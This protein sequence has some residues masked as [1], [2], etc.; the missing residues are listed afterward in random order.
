MGTRP[1][2]DRAP[3]SPLSTLPQQARRARP[4]V[5]LEAL[6]PL[7][8]WP[9]W[10]LCAIYVLPGFIGRDPW[11]AEGVAFG[12][13]W[14]IA[15]GHASWLHPTLYGSAV[16]GG[17]LAYWIGAAS[18]RLLGASLG[19]VLAARLPFALMLGLSMIQTWY[20]AYQL[21]RR[22]AALP[23][24][25][26]FAPPIPARDYARAM[27]DGALLSLVACLGLLVRGHEI[28]PALLQLT[29]SSSLLLAA[30][31]MS[32]APWRAAAL[33]A[34][35]LAALAGGGAPTLAFG[36]L[37]AG[38][39]LLAHR[40]LAGVRV[41]AA[42]ALLVGAA[43]LVVAWHAVARPLPSAP[44]PTLGHDLGNAAWFLWPA[45]PLA[46]WAL[47]RWRA[48]WTEW[49]V[50]APAALLALTL[51]EGMRVSTRSGALLSA[52]PPAALLAALAL[53]V[54]RRGS[55]AALDWFALMFFSL[56][57]FVVWLLWL[58]TL[59][60]FPRQPAA[61]IARLA[62]GYHALLHPLPTLLALA[63]TL[64]WAAV[65]A[66]RAGRHRHPLWKGMVLSAGGVTLVWVLVGTLWLPAL[67]YASTY[68]PLGRRLGAVLR[69]QA[70]GGVHC[71]GLSLAQQAL[72]GYWSGADLGSG[73]HA[74]YRLQHADRRLPPDMRVLWRG[75][76]PGEADDAFV[77]LGPR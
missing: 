9:L 55:L 15:S 62:P 77:L 14:Q 32:L 28:G 6:A 53:P 48:S 24:Q 30:A 8:R 36:A 71:A 57:A 2:R 58:A 49:H 4:V 21:A 5:A 43:A 1:A 26:A 23:V 7:P 51:L 12:T 67:N 37:L 50:L 59:T 34:L 60:G 40:A 31:W 76:R 44:W 56:F 69:T 33:G 75:H 10:L 38:A 46:L 47:W 20:A 45:W 3:E 27:A 73:R 72:L 29:A 74:R 41:Q 39:A 70:A 25:P 65:V 52:L 18:V 54:M 68:R 66:W 61:N 22:D 42:L 63:A 11:T 19:T 35:A 17:W 16:D 64:A 13:I